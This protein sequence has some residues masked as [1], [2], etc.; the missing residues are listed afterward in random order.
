MEL[1][2]DLLSVIP[3]TAGGRAGE[4]TSYMELVLQLMSSDAD[5]DVISSQVTAFDNVAQEK[6]EN[7]TAFFRRDRDANALRGY[8]FFSS[9]S[10]GRCM[11]RALW[12]IR[13]DVHELN[14]ASK[15]IEVSVRYAQRKGDICRR[16]DEEVRTKWSADS[17]E[18]QIQRTAARHVNAGV[19]TTSGSPPMPSLYGEKANLG[20]GTNIL[21]DKQG[22]E[23]AHR[24]P[25]SACISQKHFT[26]HCLDLSAETHAKLEKMRK[27]RVWTQ[28]RTPRGAVGTAQAVASKGE[29]ISTP[30]LKG[31]SAPNRTLES[32]RTLRESGRLPQKTIEREA[33][34]GVF[35]P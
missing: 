4:V 6:N 29:G 23:R 3:S 33:P 8:I 32:Q 30:A 31:G 24:Y 16:R 9:Q 21:V 18:R 13:A 12:E 1:K 25:C 27:E 28:G 2:K 22:Q 34:R 15:R 14:T 17:A 20:A 7:E 35:F 11:Q 10:K 26:R 5:E 19:T